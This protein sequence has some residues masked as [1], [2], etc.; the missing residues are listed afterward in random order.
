VHA[1]E[2]GSIEIVK[3]M[4]EMYEAVNAKEDTDKLRSESLLLALLY[5]KIDVADSLFNQ[6]QFEFGEL[7]ERYPLR[8]RTRYHERVL[9]VLAYVCSKGYSESVKWFLDKGKTYKDRAIV[10]AARFGQL[11]LVKML[12]V[13]DANVNAD[14]GAALRYAVYLDRIEMARLLLK[15]GADRTLDGWPVFSLDIM[16]T[17]RLMELGLVDWEEFRSLSAEQLVQDE[18]WLYHWTRQYSGKYCP[19][20]EGYLWEAHPDV[21]RHSE[22]A[23]R[24]AEMRSLIRSGDEGT[25]QL[26]T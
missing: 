5:R 24:R 7:D 26:G 3:E 18:D 10:F 20:R 11:D 17:E 13:E 15:N 25:S 16:W 8:D 2:G 21:S 4:L 1:V 23:K 19:L 12:L 9:K 14:S 22:R 6:Q